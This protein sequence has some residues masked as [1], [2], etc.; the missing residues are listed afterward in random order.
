MFIFDM[1]GKQFSALQN[2]YKRPLSTESANLGVMKKN[3]QSNAAL[4]KHHCLE[5]CVPMLFNK[6]SVVFL[7]SD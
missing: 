7:Q 2:I 5:T 1:F 4:L 3:V 6:L